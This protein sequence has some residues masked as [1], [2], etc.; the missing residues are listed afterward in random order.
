MGLDAGVYAD[1]GRLMQSEW[2]ETNG[3]GDYAASTVSGINTRRQHG[4]YIA[5]PPGG[6]DCRLLCAKLDESIFI[7]GQRYDLGAN[8]YQGAIH[9]Q[10]Y[11]FLVDFQSFPWP[12]WTYQIDRVRIEKQVL[13]PHGRRACFVG[14]RLVGH[15][16]LVGLELRPL[17]A[18]RDCQSL[19]IENWNFRRQTQAHDRRLEMTPYDARSRVMLLHPQATF[20]GDGFWFYK[21]VYR[22]DEGRQDNDLE[23]LFS[24]GAIVSTL[25]PNGTLWTIIAPQHP[26]DFEPRD[27]VAAERERREQ[28]RRTTS[29]PLRQR[30]LTAAAAFRIQVDDQPAVVAGYPWHG[31]RLRDTLRAL[32]GLTLAAGQP[33]LA[34]TMLTT[35]GEELRQPQHPDRAEAY[36]VDGPLWYALAAQRY[37]AATGD[38]AFGQDVVRPAVSAWLRRMETGPL[39]GIW[40]EPDGLLAQGLPDRALTWMDS[41]TE[42]G[43][44]TPRRGKAVE[45]N[46]LWHAAL[47]LLEQLG[48]TLEPSSDQVADAFRARFWDPERGYLLDVADGPDGDD[49]S[50]R[51]NQ[52]FAITCDP[53]LLDD[54]V[55]A[56]VLEAVTERLLTDRG[57]HTLEPGSWGYC[58]H[59][60]PG[61]EHQGA[62]WPWLWGPYV[63]A[64]RRLQP[65]DEATVTELAELVNQQIDELCLG[66]LTERFD[67]D[68]PHTPR[69]CFA[70]ALTVAEL[71]RITA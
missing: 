27:V 18:G 66:Q 48:E 25:R 19:M 36:S 56:R 50:C 4:L 34:K 13:M 59:E 39:P 47:R 17:L 23:D 32:P 62:V 53:T 8:E 37:L 22:A 71:L 20:S 30:L 38:H 14:Y 9:P 15:A 31:P 29:D 1:L 58:G 40:V 63:D 21:F 45:L 43:P 61:A 33:E 28:L 6:S 12:T 68:E 54:D 11:R 35:I 26:G 42:G 46:A 24:P 52:L 16:G 70:H 7:D 3:L 2:L 60:Q 57:L 69:G 65:D 44:S 10:G 49:E 64:V 5:G 51:P 67:G 55:A 41:A